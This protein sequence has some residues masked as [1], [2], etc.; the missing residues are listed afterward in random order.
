[1][2]NSEDMSLCEASVKLAS[3]SARAIL[4][5]NHNI[6]AEGGRTLVRNQ[7]G[8]M[9]RIKEMSRAGWMLIGV[10]GALLLVP[11]VASAASTIYNGIIGISGQ[12][13]DVSPTSQLLTGEAAPSAF[14]HNFAT[15]ASATVIATPPPGHALVVSGLSIDFFPGNPT[16]YIVV[17]IGNSSCASHLLNVAVVNGAAIWNGSSYVLSGGTQTVPVS[18]GLAVPAADRL[19]A[20][21]IG[22]SSA[23]VMV[24][25]YSV[26]SSSVT[27]PR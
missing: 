13:A 5:G 4:C 8:N 1:L 15:P 18:P 10:V 19:C 2:I 12:K 3:A 26:T 21:A 24:S 20:T 27:A 7:G 16:D 17:Y 9:S 11:S 25:G 23:D 22:G 14:Y 6:S